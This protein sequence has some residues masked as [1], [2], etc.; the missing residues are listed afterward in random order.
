MTKR[1]LL[2]SLTIVLSL[3]AGALAQMTPWLQW[4]FLPDSIMD[5][6]IGESS[7]ENAWHAIMETGGYDKIRP[8]SEYGPQSMFHETKFYLDKLKEYSIPGVEVVRYPGGNTWN[9]VKGEL[10][11]I[12]PGHQKL[13]SYQDM[14]AMLASGSVTSDVTAELVWVGSGRKEEL[15][16]KDLKEKIAVTDGSVGLV[17]S[18]GA[19]GVIGI[20]SSR[21]YF[22]PLQLNWASIGGGRGGGAGTSTLK[23][24]FQ[25]PPRDGDYLKKR[26]LAGQKIKVRAQVVTET[27]PTDV[28]NVVCSI[29]GTDP[30][31]G[32]IIFS[33]H[34]FEGYVKQGG[35]D[36]L[37]GCAA[38]METARVL[39]TLSN[40]DRI[41]R[42]K[43]T[44]RFLIGPEISG[45]GLWVKNHPEIMAR[46]LCN[47][48]LDMVGEWLSK[49]Q[50]FFC[51]MRTTYGNPHYI[52]DVMENYY[53]YVGESNREHLQNRG[54][55]TLQTRRIV[56]PSGADE[57]F[58]YSIETYYGSSDHVVFND[59]GVRVPGIMMIAWPDRWYHTSGDHVDK[60]DATQMKRVTI[61]AAAAAFTIA[62]ADDAMAMKIAGEITS[63]GTS[64]LGHQLM[65]ALEELNRAKAENFTEAYATGRAIITAAVINEKDT[66]ATV[67]QLAVEKKVVGDYV[68]AMQK[69]IDDIGKAHLNSL[70][71]HMKAVARKLGAAPAV[72]QMTDLEKQ[73][74]KIIPKTTSKVKE[75]GYQGWRDYM[76]SSGGGFGLGR[77]GPP[78][79]AQAADNPRAKAFADAR[80]K[81]PV[82]GRLNTGELQ[83]LIN[84]QHSA[85]EIKYMLDAQGQSKN[86][87]QDILNYLEQLKA[88]GLVEK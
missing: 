15:E 7:G 85:L 68:A 5:E 40:E 58:I 29:P 6:I 48:N 2:F 13:S 27:V 12:E 51:L 88:V 9:G 74:A 54:N 55:T 4:T 10:W 63:N 19:V 3:G 75:N 70:E 39:N 82:K 25:I 49:N 38:L 42:P 46:T 67:N 30:N 32:E 47:I 57:P 16:G 77:G 76:P 50:S 73:A 53:R 11:E 86:D 20:G 71:T 65:R 8:K 44:I 14:T 24:G 56:A 64:R 87:L 18:A 83:L 43:R 80:A 35:N 22:D 26:L 36:D 45:T 37:S 78:P 34:L 81:F 72:L 61:I 60:S 66:L 79:D 62:S 84:G 52:N 1:T 33:A 21:P 31:A 17:G 23:F 41:P 69:S 59:W 28:Q